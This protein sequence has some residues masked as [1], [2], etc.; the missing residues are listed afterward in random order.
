MC[1]QVC[2]SQAPGARVTGGFELLV[3]GVGNQTSVPWRSSDCSS[4][5]SHPFSP[6]FY[7]FIFIYLF[8]C[9]CVFATLKVLCCE[10]GCGVPEVDVGH[11]P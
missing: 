3:V 6:L 1:V 10:C 7:S 9:V 4:L 5:L 8:V 2:G 11:P